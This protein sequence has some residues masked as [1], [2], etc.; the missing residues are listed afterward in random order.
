MLSF[1]QM[2]RSSL[3]WGDGFVDDDLYDVLRPIDWDLVTPDE[4]FRYQP[5]SGCREGGE[6]RLPITWAFADFLQGAEAN[7]TLSRLPF[8]GSGDY[9]RQAEILVEGLV[10]LQGD[11]IPSYDEDHALLVSFFCGVHPAYIWPEALLSHERF[12]T[13]TWLGKAYRCRRAFVP[14]E[15]ASYLCDVLTITGS[16]LDASLKRF[17]PRC[18]ARRVLRRV[19]ERRT[20]LGTAVF[21]TNILTRGCR[22]SGIF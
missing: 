13:F 21:Q 3:V 7:S 22:L 6:W 16:C 14:Q 18:Q 9:K 2:D 4:L 8:R 5:N 19:A 15:V 11:A 17:L 20:R 1:V 10:D 12:T